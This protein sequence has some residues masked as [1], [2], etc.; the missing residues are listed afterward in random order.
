MIAFGPVTVQRSCLQS[1]CKHCP[2]FGVGFYCLSSSAT[3]RAT[4]DGF[5][6]IVAKRNAPSPAICLIAVDVTTH[7]HPV[8]Q[9]LSRASPG[10]QIV[11]GMARLMTSLSGRSLIPL[12]ARAG[13]CTPMR[14][15]HIGDIHPPS[16]V[17]RP[18]EGGYLLAAHLNS[19]HIMVLSVILGSFAAIALCGFVFGLL[20]LAKAALSK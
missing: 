2:P 17:S 14:W 3:S 16:R 5:L 6:Q 8:E 7:N 1:S 13:C 20:G 9:S 19:I 15:F 11:C 4:G 12:V 18:R 10:S